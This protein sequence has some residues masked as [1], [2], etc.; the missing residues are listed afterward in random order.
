M[1]DAHTP[2]I[3]EKEVHDSFAHNVHHVEKHYGG[4]GHKHH[5]HHVKDEHMAKEDGHKMHHEHVKAMCYG[6]KA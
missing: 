5:Q 1:K 6:G 2:F 3:K 4:D